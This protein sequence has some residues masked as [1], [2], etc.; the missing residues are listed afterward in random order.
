MEDRLFSEIRYNPL[1]SIENKRIILAFLQEL[2]RIKDQIIQ[3]FCNFF[4]KKIQKTEE[5]MKKVNEIFSSNND[6]RK[7]FNKIMDDLYEKFQYEEKEFMNN[8]DKKIG[9]MSLLVSNMLLKIKTTIIKINFQA[10]LQEFLQISKT[11]ISKTLQ[12]S[13]FNNGNKVTFSSALFRSIFATADLL[14]SFISGW[15]SSGSFSVFSRQIIEMG[16]VPMITDKELREKS[17]ELIEAYE[18][19]IIL[20]KEQRKECERHINCAIKNIA[21]ILV[22]SFRKKSQK[23]LY[24]FLSKDQ[25]NMFFYEMLKD[26]F[27]STTS[28]I[29]LSDEEEVRNLKTEEI[30]EV[31]PFV[32]ISS[33]KFY[34]YINEMIIYNPMFKGLIIYTS[35]CNKFAS[36]DKNP[37]W[38]KIVT[39]EA[40]E[41]FEKTKYF[42]ENLEA[43]S[44]FTHFYSLISKF[45][46]DTLKCLS[47]KNLQINSLKDVR[48]FRLEDLFMKLKSWDFYEFRWEFG[49][50]F[51]DNDYNP[52]FNYFDVNSNYQKIEQSY[53][54]KNSK[55]FENDDDEQSFIKLFSKVFKNDLK[56]YNEL[57]HSKFPSAFMDYFVLFPTNPLDP[58]YEIMFSDYLHDQ[59]T[60]PGID[61][62]HVKK[63]ALFER[64]KYIELVLNLIR[65]LNREESDE[66]KILRILRLYTSEDFFKRINKY[67]LYMNHKVL[68]TFKYVLGTFIFAFSNFKDG[69]ELPKFCY[70][71]V[72]ID[73]ATFKKQYKIS[74]RLVFPSFTSTSV[75]P[76]GV[77][78]GNI[79]LIIQTN[80]YMENSEKPKFLAGISE[81][82]NE[83]EVLFK[84]FSCFEILRIQKSE[85]EGI[86]YDCLMKHI[87]LNLN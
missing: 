54:K 56:K 17:K 37:K 60:T 48:L 33:S 66:Y 80:P 40:Y 9:E 49:L 42:L 47:T 8:L 67:F 78:L 41:V 15:K 39:Q 72:F 87:L 43:N 4:E 10:K 11:S 79:R 82:Q 32:I 19:Y 22:E 58:L 44:Y 30:E 26:A 63:N 74:D 45:E 28:I 7:D 57:F 59:M 84:C 85:I 76:D 69:K 62:N 14:S 12:N 3:E 38:P 73:G 64:E 53:I 77:K 1:L 24:L 13:Q 61:A 51:S 50:N 83:E 31:I 65:I 70:R 68:E 2:V 34:L 6:R 71:T 21:K 46:G 23:L 35:D 5:I 25:E 29:W 36:L 52:Q 20:C 27:G 81:N 55:V 75:S 16:A 18:N 86:E